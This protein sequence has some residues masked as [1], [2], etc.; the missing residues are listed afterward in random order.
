MGNKPD[1]MEIHSR[2][3]DAKNSLKSWIIA[4]LRMLAILSA[5]SGVLALIFEVRTL[6]IHSL[7]VYISRLAATVV[8]FVVLVISQTEFGKKKP[9][10]LVHI[11]V[12]AVILS[13]GF[14]VYRIPAMFQ[15]NSNIVALY[16]FM[17]GLAMGWKY[18]HQIAVVIYFIAIYLGTIITSPLLYSNTQILV[19][20]SSIV[21]VLC[22]MSVVSSIIVYQTKEKLFKN[23]D[24]NNQSSS[25]DE[26]SDKF[27]NFIENSPI[28]FYRFQQNGKL[29]FANA[30]FA[31]I[32]GFESVSEISNNNIYDLIFKDSKERKRLE[33]IL[34]ENGKIKNF[35]M[36]LNKKDGSEIIV[37][38]DESFVKHEDESLNY[39][40]GNLVDITHQAA[41][42]KL[43]K[44][45]FEKLKAESTHANYK[46][47]S[48][49]YNSQVKSQFLAKMSHE[50]RT[51]MNSVLGFL[52]L[53]E[54][55]L[56]ESEE[57]LRDFARNARISADSL[58]DIINNVLDLSKIEA[59]KMKLSE[60]EFS[61]RE[62]IEKAISIIQ[63][64]VKEKNLQVNSNVYSGVPISVFGDSIRYRQVVVNLLSNASK[65]TKAGSISVDVDVVKKTD[66][67]IK[68]LTTVTDTGI[69]IKKE[70]LSQLF[71]PYIQLSSEKKINRKGTGLG[72]IICKDFVSLM[73]GKI[74]VESE[75]GKGTKIQFTVVLGLEKNFLKTNDFNELKENDGIVLESDASVENKQTIPEK[76]ELSEEKN[77]ELSEE[78]SSDKIEKIDS[79]AIP[80]PKTLVEP[81]EN[82][83]QSFPRTTMS[84]KR[85]LLV[86]DNPISQ[87]VELKLLRETGYSVDP[88]SNAYDAI[89]AIKSNAFNLVLM[90]IEMEDIDGIEATKKIRALEP[91]VN[92][93]PIIA[94]TAHSSMKDRERCLDAGMDDYI[95]KPINIHFLK[96]TIDQWLNAER[97]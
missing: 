64:N 49:V 57:E 3:S 84:K 23:Y 82:N 28:A 78:N 55:G 85:L 25:I 69:G 18:V 86:E 41:A 92:K 70:K 21:L 87:R 59:G 54:N 94:V 52:T 63:T 61:I 37:K 2:Q 77:V 91:P 9:E 95:A 74:D 15:V 75:E 48:A 58:L 71:K 80:E 34:S 83:M 42:E 60:D 90:D 17:I 4:P 14:V 31:K 65:Y 43:R 93:I 8:A 40:E 35:R 72:L 20:T 44:N 33:K 88:V 68:I 45:E 51:P 73:G 67:T 7:E 10:I 39:Y 50:I 56:F 27:K 38:L 81:I 32:F 1:N 97:D 53:M 62:E 22:L 36:K 89:A 76:S 79:A 12:F 30:A 46:A 11:M 24:E 19:E 29:L 47:N 13:S 6:V 16:V 96:M 5:I 66:A 26:T